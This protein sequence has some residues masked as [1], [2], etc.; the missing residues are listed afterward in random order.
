MIL[1]YGLA[2]IAAC[3]AQAST[4]LVKLEDGKSQK[5]QENVESL[6]R[7]V[8]E[9]GMLLENYRRTILNGIT[10]ASDL[11]EFIDK[12]SDIEDDDKIPDGNLIFQ[13]TPSI[14]NRLSSP[15]QQTADTMGIRL[16]K[17]FFQKVNDPILKSQL[18]SSLENHIDNCFARSPNRLVA[19]RDKNQI[20]KI[21]FHSWGGKR[22]RGAPKVVIRT[23]FHSWGGKRSGGKDV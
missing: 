12:L 2:I 23:P 22:N 4:G 10:E 17:G 19:K 11:C 13:L 1:L 21:R 3:S 9:M 15:D 18:F 8:G 14:C 20:Q 7:Q 16:Y 6:M 5:L